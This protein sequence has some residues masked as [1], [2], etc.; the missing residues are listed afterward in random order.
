MLITKT[1]TG[2]G[3]HDWILF[4]D[5]ISGFDIEE[6]HSQF[7]AMISLALVQPFLL[8]VETQNVALPEARKAVKTLKK[9]FSFALFWNYL[10]L[11]S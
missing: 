4:L 2:I 8:V 6:D 10:S 1:S 7:F 3:G 11:D 9:V 5:L